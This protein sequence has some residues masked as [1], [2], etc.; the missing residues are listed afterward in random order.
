MDINMNVVIYDLN[1]IPMIAL[2]LKTC[3]IILICIYISFK[4]MYCIYYNKSF[5]N[6]IIIS[7]LMLFSV[8]I[9]SYHMFNTLDVITD[10]LI[11]FMLGLYNI[12]ILYIVKYIYKCFEL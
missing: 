1:I 6:D 3:D 10:I 2:L 9:T 8:G 12:V 7:I 5:E 4:Y 11:I